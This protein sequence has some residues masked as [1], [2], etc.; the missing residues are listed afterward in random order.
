M[1]V[2]EESTDVSTKKK[3]DF[4]DDDWDP[5]TLLKLRSVK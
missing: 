3:I 1:Q 5:L 4:N 2:K